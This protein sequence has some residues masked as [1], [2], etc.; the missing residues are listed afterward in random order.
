MTTI[1]KFCKQYRILN[2]ISLQL[3]LQINFPEATQNLVRTYFNTRQTHTSCTKF[4]KL[5]FQRGNTNNYEC[6]PA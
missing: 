2:F 5:N 3:T 4:A 6:Y 1:Q